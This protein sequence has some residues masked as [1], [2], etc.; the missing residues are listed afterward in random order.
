MVVTDMLHNALGWTF[1]QM[2]QYKTK[3][4]LQR[5][6]NM[7]QHIVL[8]AERQ[9]QQEEIKALRLEK[10]LQAQRERLG[11][12][13][14]D[15]L[16]S[17]LTH[18]ISRLDLLACVNAPDPSQLLRLSQFACEMNQT[19]RETIWLLDH[20]TITA[21]AFGARLH[22][23]LLKVWDDRDTPTLQW[24]FQ[25]TPENPVLPPLVALHLVRIAQEGTNNALK[26]AGATQVS[27]KLAVHKK[28]L[29][30][31]ILDNGYGFDGT[32]AGAGFGLSNMRK[33]T[34]EAKGSFNLRTG[35]SGTAI[36]VTLPLNV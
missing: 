16:G 15:G 6:H 27:I 31:T 10:E 35:L 24:Q 29:Q 14:H 20:E 25:N 18:I 34:E 2:Q 7:L 19:L 33:R 17:Q 1:R 11:R 5:A 8:E 28:D 13:L 22:S 26:Y 23:M 36:K 3:E 12:D 9:R 32:K 4:E 21:A 30:L